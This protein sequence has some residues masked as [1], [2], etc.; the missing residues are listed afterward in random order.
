MNDTTTK[1]DWIDIAGRRVF[2]SEAW[3]K[4]VESRHGKEE[5]DRVERIIHFGGNIEAEWPRVVREVT[6]A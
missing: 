4:Y 1:Q 5:A 2:W 3:Y 6:A